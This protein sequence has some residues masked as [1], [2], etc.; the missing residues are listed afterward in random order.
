MRLSIN[1]DCDYW[2]RSSRATDKLL[3][4]L[5]EHHDYAV[6][7]TF[8]T[9]KQV[10]EIVTIPELSIPVEIGILPIPEPTLTID[11]IKRVVCQHFGISHTDLVSPRRDHKVQRPRM[12][13]MWLAR[14]LTSHGLPALGRSFCRD[15][16]SV[17]HSVRKMDGMVKEGIDPLTRDAGYLR[18]VLTA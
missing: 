5:K 17:L 15:H 1:D 11:G 18:E 2:V 9:K 13:A 16:T 7:Y 10:I 8:V 4:M 14:E 6:P 12:L 3:G